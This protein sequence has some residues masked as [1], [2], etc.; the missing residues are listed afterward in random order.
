MT[1]ETKKPER[2]LIR[3]DWALK[4]LLRNKANFDVLEGF[5][6][7]LTGEEMTITSIGESESNR[8][9]SEDKFNRVDI[10]AENGRNGIFIIEVQI[11]SE[12][13]Y[14]HRMLYGVSKA[15]SE[16]LS[17]DEYAGIR[18]IYH[19]NIVYFELGQG[20]DYVYHGRNDFYGIHRHD[21][22]LLSE[23]QKKKYLRME[24]GDLFPEYY[25][26]RVDDFDGVARDNLDQWIYYLKTSLIPEEF[27]APGLA[28]A[29]EKL[30]YERL[31]EEE[32]RDYDH[33]REQLRYEKSVISTSHEEGREEGR[34]E[35]RIRLREELEEKDKVIGEKE[36]TIEEKEK[37]IAELKR[38][39][40]SNR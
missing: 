17:G 26:L 36:K 6:S 37:E 15:A 11:S 10:R 30:R 31:S 1:T 38:L 20:E 29:R 5:L 40:N 2:N 9:S 18:K 39:L 32:R 7:V 22:L 16:L 34:R 4:R 35:E 3:F 24:A 21:R 14:F 23:R 28:V 27:T 12:A 33:H 19:I 8:T 13:D 25:I